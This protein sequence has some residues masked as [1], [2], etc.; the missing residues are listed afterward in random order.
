M[1]SLGRVENPVDLRDRNFP[2]SLVAPRAPLPSWSFWPGPKFR[3]DQDLI[4]NVNGGF[5]SCVGYCGENW[6]GATPVRD[7]V[8]NQDGVNLYNSCKLIDGIPNVEGTYD[9]AL[10]KVLQARGRIANYLWASNANE[11]WQ[12]VLGTG[13]AMVGT[14]WYNS[15]F[16]P[17]AHHVLHVDKASGIAGGHEWLII[18][19]VGNWYLMRNTWGGGWGMNGEAW[20]RPADLYDLVFNQGG[21]AL[22]AVEM[23]L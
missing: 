14:N 23:P 12:W 20:I 9:R 17:D 19:L 7:G 1:P 21:D 3:V 2:M 22:G 4:R 11:L 6:L 5:G 16:T 15:M 10:V 18:G 13:P 8:S